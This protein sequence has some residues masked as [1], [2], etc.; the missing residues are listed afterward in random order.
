[1]NLARI[2]G[3][4]IVAFGIFILNYFDF[5]DN[6]S[7]FIFGLLVGLGFILIIKGRFKGSV[8]L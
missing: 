2:T 1:M 3:I 8:K 7:G 6:M 5:E 4:L